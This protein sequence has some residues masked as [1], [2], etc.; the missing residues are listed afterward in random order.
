MS[1]LRPSSADRPTRRD[2]LG[3]IARLQDLVGEALA[4][5]R[6]DIARDRPKRVEGPLEEA[7]DICIRASALEPPMRPGEAEG[8]VGRLWHPGGG[9]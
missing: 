8:A 1:A 7:H 9:T 2:L 3:V 5:S 4:A 6:D